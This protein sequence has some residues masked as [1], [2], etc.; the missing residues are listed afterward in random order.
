MGPFSVS[1]KIQFDLLFSS[2]LEV[3]KIQDITIAGMTLGKLFNIE[4]GFDHL[5]KVDTC[6]D[7]HT[8]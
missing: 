5:V 6:V 2:S 7:T 8:L 1:G 4:T 3:L